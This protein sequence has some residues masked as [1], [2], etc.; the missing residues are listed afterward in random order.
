MGSVLAETA[1]GAGHDSS[2]VVDASLASTAQYGERAEAEQ[3]AADDVSRS[4]TIEEFEGTDGKTTDLS[5]SVDSSDVIG[6]LGLDLDTSLSGY[7]LG[8]R[9]ISRT[10]EETCGDVAATSSQLPYDSLA[11]VTTTDDDSLEDIESVVDSQHTH[12]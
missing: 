2:G 11:Q 9:P 8:Q 6:S 5:D 10:E 1:A 3:D 7:L 4:M 12:L